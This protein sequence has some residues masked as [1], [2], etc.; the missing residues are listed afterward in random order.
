VIFAAVLPW[1]HW[2]IAGIELKDFGFIRND[3]VS[4]S[5]PLSSTTASMA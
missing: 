5:I 3:E 1:H 4:G 2:G